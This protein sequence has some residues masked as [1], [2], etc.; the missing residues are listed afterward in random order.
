MQE[1]V[2][3]IAA[4]RC[5]RTCPPGQPCACLVP[6]PMGLPAWFPPN[7]QTMHRAENG[8]DGNVAIS[9]LAM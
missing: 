3:G 7:L 1:Q 5:L 8:Q 4:W 2:C 6:V 9:V